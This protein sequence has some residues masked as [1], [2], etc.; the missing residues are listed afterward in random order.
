MER[1]FAVL[2]HCLP[3]SG[4][5]HFDVFFEM[6]E[7]LFS[8]KSMESP[9][10]G[11]FAAQRQFDHRKKYLSYEGDISGGRGFVKMWDC[12]AMLGEVAL[13]GDFVVELSGARLKGRYRVEKQGESYRVIAL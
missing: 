11:D 8:L 2:F 9:D 1:R 6:D 13:D 10:L 5:S 12:G 3:Q 7:S 4:D